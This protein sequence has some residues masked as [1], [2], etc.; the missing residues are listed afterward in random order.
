M[1]TTANKIR[2]LLGTALAWSGAKGRPTASVTSALC[3]QLRRNFD[4]SGR[5]L[6][7]RPRR[8]PGS[9]G[10]HGSAGAWSWCRAGQRAAPEPTA[11]ARG[12]ACAAPGGWELHPPQAHDQAAG[13]WSRSATKITCE[14]VKVQSL[15]ALG[16]QTQAEGTI[17][18]KPSH[19]SAC[20]AAIVT[21]ISNSRCWRPWVPHRWGE[22]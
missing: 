1:H 8:W 6:P 16:A 18:A 19:L 22:P 7:P 17:L 13:A 15:P 5:L 9:E 11:A 4:Q 10:R 2:G 12:A 20:A 21:N 3:K 14:P